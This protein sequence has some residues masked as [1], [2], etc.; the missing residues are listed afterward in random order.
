M[1]D[2]N[3]SPFQSTSEM[4]ISIQSSEPPSSPLISNSF[5]YNLPDPTIGLPSSA[6]AGNLNTIP[7]P[8]KRSTIAS[9][10]K[11][12]S[13]EQT[14]ELQ[15]HRRTLPLKHFFSD[16]LQLLVQAMLVDHKRT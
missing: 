14:Q 2:E 16:L 4:S 7:S 5:L 1:N 8:L 11:P 9:L 10:N 12:L 13:R 15:S 6:H 3:M